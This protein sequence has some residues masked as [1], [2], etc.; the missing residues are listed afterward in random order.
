MKLVIATRNEGK[1]REIR[2]ILEDIELEV[3]GLE[4]FPDLPEVIEDGDTFSANARKKAS[5]IARLT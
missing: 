4:N 2:Q 3:I 5:A 1:L